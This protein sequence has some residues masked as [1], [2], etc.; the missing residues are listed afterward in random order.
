MRNW[1]E[2]VEET[3]ELEKFRVG[4]GVR[5]AKESHRS[6]GASVLC[7][8]LIGSTESHWP[9]LTGKGNGSFG[10]G[11]QCQNLGE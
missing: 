8:V 10:G 11:N 2:G 3:Q 9:L 7:D 6:L 4:G 1:A 5:R